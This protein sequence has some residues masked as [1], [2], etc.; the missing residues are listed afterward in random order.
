MTSIRHT[1]PRDGKHR[2][3]DRDVRRQDLADGVRDYYD[4]QEP[5]I[6]CSYNPDR[7]DTALEEAGKKLGEHGITLGEGYH[8][9]SPGAGNILI[10]EAVNWAAK[11]LDYG[12][13]ELKPYVIAAAARDGAG[14]GV[15]VQKSEDE[16]GQIVWDLYHP[17]VGVASFHDPYGE[18]ETLVNGMETE[19]DFTPR[20]FPWSGVERQ[21]EAFRMLA[22][23]EAVGEMAVRTAPEIPGKSFA[24]RFGGRGNGE[25]ER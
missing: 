17:E 7:V 12:F 21:S 2:R 6:T 19:V 10:A 23:P 15:Y 18:V 13:Y 16:D 14:R 8:S 20:P 3:D 5:E 9:V 24:E 4:Q 22:D 1:N 11:S 25:R